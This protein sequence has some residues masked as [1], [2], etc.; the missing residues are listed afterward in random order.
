MWREFTKET[1]A[2]PWWALVFSALA[3]AG[4][5]ALAQYMTHAKG[6]SRTTST[7]VGALGW[8]FGFQLPEGFHRVGISDSLREP[9]NAEGTRGEMAFKRMELRRGTADLRVYFQWDDEPIATDRMFHTLTGLSPDD[10]EVIDL[11]PLSG[12]WTMGVSSEGAVVWTA[13]ATAAEGLTLQI[14]MTTP[15]AGSRQRREFEQ[16][17]SSVEYRVWAIRRPY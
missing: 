11:G 8:P 7:L 13:V 17:C 12:I 9:V 3:L 2:R 14:E 6:S 15:T 10:A 4:T 1:P 5:T 16:I